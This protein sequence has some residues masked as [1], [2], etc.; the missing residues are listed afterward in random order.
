MPVPLH[1]SRRKQRGFDQ[2]LLLSRPL[3]SWLNVRKFLGLSRVRPTRAQ[4]GLDHRQRRLNVRQAFVL[5]SKKEL[6]GKT[7]LLVDDVMTTGATVCEISRVLKREGRVERVRVL[8][9]SRVARYPP[10]AVAANP[11]TGVYS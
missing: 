6:A 5:K 9:L 2:T 1:P 8:T 4:F 11:P 10:A 7:V 3:S